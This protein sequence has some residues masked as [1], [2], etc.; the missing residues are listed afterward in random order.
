MLL[1]IKIDNQ[2]QVN[3]LFLTTG[4]TLSPVVAYP[5]PTRR[6]PCRRPSAFLASLLQQYWHQNTGPSDALLCCGDASQCGIGP[7]D[8]ADPYLMAYDELTTER[9]RE[10]LHAYIVGIFGTVLKVLNNG[11]QVPLQLLYSENKN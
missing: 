2:I 7:N 1:R 10:A 11:F 9:F 5:E 4:Q 3:L 8:A 6:R